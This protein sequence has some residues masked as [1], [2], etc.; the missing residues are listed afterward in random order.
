MAFD[1]EERVFLTEV[2]AQHCL[3]Y[4]NSIWYHQ[5]DIQGDRFFCLSGRNLLG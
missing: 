2:A 4:Y 5:R 1:A 3:H